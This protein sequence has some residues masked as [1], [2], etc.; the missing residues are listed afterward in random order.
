MNHGNVDHHW[1]VQ[2]PLLPVVARH[3]G[4]IHKHFWRQIHG[5]NY[6]VREALQNVAMQ[7]YETRCSCYAEMGTIFGLCVLPMMIQSA[8]A[9]RITRGKL[10][11]KTG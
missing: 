7:D 3:L 9:D 2:I 1:K 6:F 4:N 5:R 10:W 11:S 8:R